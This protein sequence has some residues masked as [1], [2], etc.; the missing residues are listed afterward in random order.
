MHACHGDNLCNMRSAVIWHMKV[1][2]HPGT[3]EHASREQP[4][5]HRRVMDACI[6]YTP[7]KAFLLSWQVGAGAAYAATGVFATGCF[8]RLM[9]GA[10]LVIAWLNL[11]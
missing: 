4:F 2:L 8:W 3:P 11:R 6:G 10:I 7:C 1:A 5:P 9:G